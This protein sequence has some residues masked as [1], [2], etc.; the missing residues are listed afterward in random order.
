MKNGITNN[1]AEEIARFINKVAILE[2]TTTSDFSDFPKIERFKRNP[3][4][5]SILRYL[6][7]NYSYCKKCGLPWNHCKNKSVKT[8]TS[9][10]TFAT[11]DVCWDNS[12]LEELKGYYTTVYK[13]QEMLAFGGGFEMNHTLEHLLSCVEAEY[14]R[15]HKIK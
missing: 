12:T 13:K 5:A 14:N 3:Q 6:N 15:T 7:M 11:C 4:V 9:D 2:K 1:E 8:S 10:G